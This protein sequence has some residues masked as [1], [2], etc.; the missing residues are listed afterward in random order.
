ML[1]LEEK[2]GKREKHQKTDLHNVPR[3]ASGFDVRTCGSGEKSEK[4]RSEKVAIL[5][6]GGDF[7]GSKREA[8]R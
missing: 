2:V 5:R 6:S 1:K 8:K 3:R 7:W 4:T